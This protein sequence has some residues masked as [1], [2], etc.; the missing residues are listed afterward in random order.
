MRERC[1]LKEVSL[2]RRG[3][4]ERGKGWDWEEV[5]KVKGEIPGAAVQDAIT[6]LRVAITA[7]P[8]SEG[9]FESEVGQIGVKCGGV[10]EDLET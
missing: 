8:V 3:D 5:G 6:A 9:R 4:G 1:M 10:V 7:A 2:G